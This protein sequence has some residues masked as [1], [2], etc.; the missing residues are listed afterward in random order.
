MEMRTRSDGEH[1]FLWTLCRRGK[2]RVPRFR[3][4]RPAVISVLCLGAFGFMSLPAASRSESSEPE[5]VAPARSLY[6]GFSLRTGAAPVPVEAPPTFVESV[7]ASAAS[8][9][10]SLLSEISS[11]FKTA[12]PTGP[13]LVRFSLA[14]KDAGLGP[15]AALA[16]RR[17]PKNGRAWLELGLF[18]TYNHTRYWIKWWQYVEDQQFKLDFE[19]QWHRVVELHGLR[20]DSNAFST[21]WTH[22]LAGACYYQ[23]SRANARSWPQSL[24]MAFAASAWWEIVT[25]FKEVIS[26]NDLIATSAG[27]YSIGEPWFQLGDFLSHNPSPYVRWLGVLNPVNKIN[28][29]LDGRREAP[30]AYTPPGWHDLSLFA[31]AWNVAWDG[32]PSRT[33]LYF[34]FRTRIICHPDYG[35]PGRIRETVRD[36]IFTEVALNFATGNGAANE[37]N[38]TTRVVSLA[39]FRQSVDALHNGYSFWFGLGSRFSYFGKKAVWSL[40][41]DPVPVNQGYDLLLDE[42][43]NFADKLALVHVAGPVVD[44]TIF[45]GDLK[46]RTTAEAYLDFAMINAFALNEYS[47]SHDITGLK[48]TTFYYGYYYGVGTSLT[49]ESCLEWKSLRLRASAEL[50]AWGSID[51]GERFQETIADNAHFKDTRFRY[52]AGAGW[53]VPGAPLE[54][55]LDFEGIRRWGIVKTVGVSRLEKRV[56]AGL[57]LGF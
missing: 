7:P 23:F 47:V 28:E 3:H 35:K 48:T 57:Q 9:R 11:F 32:G 14:V 36:T 54:A 2:L 24:L 52:L 17:R 1:H 42:P 6:A 33:G 18:M 41:I 44:W 12:Q 37:A 38:F 51:V 25:E 27:G 20:F 40:D 46:V 22:S 4:T 13:S 56:F 5:S 15:P 26:I 29:W 16:S 39:L 34:G 19:D 49:A 21:N 55:F 8:A 50:G 30:A 53:K 10:F 31:G 45:R 43:R